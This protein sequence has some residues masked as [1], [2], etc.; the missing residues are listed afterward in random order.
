MIQNIPTYGKHPR[1]F[2]LSSDGKFIVV[3][4]MNS[5]NLTLFGR[6]PDNGRLI[7]L[8]KDVFAPEPTC[9]VF[10]DLV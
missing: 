5:D 6:N 9:C 8:Q 7:V 2:N 4:N 10:N 1:D 3:A